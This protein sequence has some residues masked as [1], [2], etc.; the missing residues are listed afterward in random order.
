M[1]LGRRLASLTGCALISENYCAPAISPSCF[2]SSQSFGIEGPSSRAV[3]ALQAAASRTLSLETPRASAWML[4]ATR[5]RGPVQGTTHPSSTILHSDTVLIMYV[6]DCSKWPEL[7]QYYLED[8][9]V[10]DIKDVKDSLIFEMELVLREEHP[11]YRAPSQDAQYCYSRGRLV[12]SGAKDVT[13]TEK[14]Y[15]NSWDA[16]GEHDWGNIDVL[17]SDDG[18]FKLQGDWGAVQLHAQRVYVE[19]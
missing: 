7:Q 10:L 19:F 8:S 3:N 4:S 12:F 1:P 16:T 11:A 17:R 13:W 15:V 14:K 2:A 6:D 5:S 18:W 9:F